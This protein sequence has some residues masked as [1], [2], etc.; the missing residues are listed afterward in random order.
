MLSRK[1]QK[2]G[3]ANASVGGVIMLTIILTILALVCFALAAFAASLVPKVNPL[4]LGLAL[5]TLAQLIPLLK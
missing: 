4:G 5:L 3:V 1:R 2:S